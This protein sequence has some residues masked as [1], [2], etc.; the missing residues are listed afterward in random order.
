MS[1]LEAVDDR[2]VITA[3]ISRESAEG[4]RKFCVANG[5]TLTALIEVAGLDLA[6]ESSPPAVEA[7][8]KMIARAREV[9]LARRSRR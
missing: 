7:R 1:E 3:K 5:V 9:D 6:V 2:K 4:W 8:I